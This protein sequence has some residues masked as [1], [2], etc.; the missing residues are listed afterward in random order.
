M[1]DFKKTPKQI[2]AVKLLSGR[3]KNIMLYG[4]SRSGKTSII[5]RSMIIRASKVKSRHIVLRL[6]F[7]HAKTSLWLDTFPKLF[8]TAFPDL[9]VALNN[10]DYYMTFPNGSEIWVAGLDDKKRTE[11]IL[12][13]EYST[14]FFNECSQIPYTSVGIAKTRL[15]EKNALVKKAYYDENPPNKKHW[16]Y[17]LFILKKDPEDWKPL[18]HPERYTSMRINPQDNIE[19][20]DEDYITEILD[21][22]SENQRLRFKYGEFTDEGEGKIY[23]SF[24]REDNCRVVKRNVNAPIWIGMDFN[25]DPMTAVIANITDDSIF[26]FDEIYL[27]NS[28]TSNMA[29]TIKEKYRNT[30]ITIIPDSTGKNRH[31]SSSTTSHEILRQ[32]GFTVQYSHNP[33]RVDRYNSVNNL[34]EKKKLLI[35]NGCIKTIRDLEQVSYKEGTNLP[36]TTDHSLGHITDG[37]GYLVY[38]THGIRHKFNA[39]IRFT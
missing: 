24:K 31:P 39:R 12:G 4:G 29:R 27:P 21:D 34:L 38:N 32:A 28:N 2:A 6:H 37:L 14:I 22:L 16:S 3:A 10:S 18:G 11:K 8:N 23:H 15:A 7:N 9:V 1:P 30:H 33:F 20:I 25:V 13:K 5:C 35:D 17:P 26:V 36:D 19:N